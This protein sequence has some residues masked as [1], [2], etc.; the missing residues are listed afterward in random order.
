MAE[1]EG[2]VEV[3]GETGGEI[4]LNVKWVKPNRG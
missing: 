1:G 2:G 4:D 3:V